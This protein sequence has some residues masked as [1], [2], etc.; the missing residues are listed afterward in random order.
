[1]SN[2]T[3]IGHRVRVARNNAGI[4]QSDLG[5]AVGVQ[6]QTI[7][8]LENRGTDA[9]SSTIIGIAR[10]C[11]VSVEWLLTGGEPDLGPAFINFLDVSPLGQSATPEELQILGA[12]HFPDDDQPPTELYE[13]WLIDLR[14]EWKKPE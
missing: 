11:A 8:A 10:A 3:E 1:M 13:K 6:G 7:W 2:G 4:T 5:H 9:K 12:A 14:S